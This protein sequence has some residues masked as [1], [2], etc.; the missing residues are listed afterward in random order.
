M[1]TQSLLFTLGL[2]CIAST[3]PTQIVLDLDTSLDGLQPSPRKLHGRFLH[4][5]DIHPDP[6]YEPGAS[7][8]SACHRANLK[9]NRPAGYYGTPYSSCDSPFSLTN[10]TLD[11]LDE[12]WTSEIDFVIWTGDN[13]RH[14]NDDEIPRPLDEIY[15]LNRAVARKMEHVFV[16]KGIPVVPSLGNND[17]WPHNKLSAG[18]NNIFEE[19]S[20]IWS[21]FIPPTSSAS[22][23]QGAYFSTE[24]IPD[25]VAA[26]SLNTLYF[27]KKNHAVGGCDYAEPKDPGNIQLD[28]LEEQLEIFRSR[29]MQVWITGHV[30]PSET[31]YFPEC[32]YRLVELNL[33]FQDTILGNLYGHLN[34]D[35]FSF[36]GADDIDMS[37]ETSS[38]STLFETLIAG[39][40]EIPEPL[41]D[42][43]YD[44]Y[45]V[46]N[47]N[48]AIVP[49]PYIPSFRIFTYNTTG[50]SSFTSDVGSDPYLQTIKATQRQRTLNHEQVR[51]F[52]KPKCER[53]EC[54]STWRCQFDKP[55]HSD[56]QSP[57]RRNSL[58]SPLGFAQYYMP[59]LA[60][61]DQTHDPEFEL[62]YMTF[63][64]SRLHP[65][66]EAQD[67]TDHQYVIPLRLLPEELRQPGV[68]ESEYTP[69]ELDDLTIPSWLD[70]ATRLTKDE[71][72]RLR[73]KE[74]MYIGGVEE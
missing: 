37:T 31:K 65:D 38:S 3:A 60:E 33:R 17:I 68:V 29:Q 12:H 72:L 57:S 21:A 9:G 50:L 7:Q 73:F 43:H 4:I 26:F 1:R 20:S 62:E 66:E 70:F 71:G 64:L 53:K 5:T 69:Y 41:V 8:S 18:P 14:D 52:K 6:F 30:P 49:N 63:P 42:T 59:R 47:V 16:S 44:N 36:L 56:S 34:V 48:G 74:F 24:V 25:A 15:D 51:T 58:W 23:H 10:A 54:R 22:F 19:F 46:V 35:H 2:C 11:F 61:F 39:F 27:Y 40:S 55:R 32:Y 45:A 13:A 67:V 28:W